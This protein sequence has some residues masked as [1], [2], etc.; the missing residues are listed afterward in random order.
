[1]ETTQTFFEKNFLIIIV[2]AVF[3]ILHFS[4]KKKQSSLNKLDLAE[5]DKSNKRPSPFY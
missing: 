2:I 5:L 4:M 3:I 1:M